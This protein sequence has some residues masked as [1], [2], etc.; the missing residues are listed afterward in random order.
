LGNAEPFESWT[1]PFIIVWADKAPDHTRKIN[2]SR[3]FRCLRGG[4]IVLASINSRFK[5]KDKV[6][7]QLPM[8]R[9]KQMLSA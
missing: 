4:G 7:G 1:E 3:G 8:M 5:L 6:V 2:K 9:R